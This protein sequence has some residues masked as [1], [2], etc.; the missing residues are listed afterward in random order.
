MQFM[1]FRPEGKRQKCGMESWTTRGMYVPFNLTPEELK[2]AQEHA[3]KIHGHVGDVAAQKKT[4]EVKKKF[5][6]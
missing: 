1:D 5:W 3:V 4:T 2:K 6:R